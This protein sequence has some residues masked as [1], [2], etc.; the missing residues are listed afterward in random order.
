MDNRAIGV[1]DS[2][3]GGLTA[4]KELHRLL[5]NEDIIY[6]G[7]TGRVPYGSRSRE[8]IIKYAQ[9]DIDFL[10]TKDIKLVLAACGTVSSTLPKEI[11]GKLPV[12][13]ADIVQPA[14]QQACALT[15]G[16]RIGVVGTNATLRSNAFGKAIRSIRADVRVFGNP[17]P[18]LVHLVENGMVQPD[19]QITNLTVQ[20]YLEPL[21]REKIDTLILGCTHYPLLYDIFNRLLG[22]QVTLIDPGKCAAGYVQ[23]YLMQHDLLADRQREGVTEYN[24]TDETD[25]FG[26]TASIFLGQEVAGTVNRVELVE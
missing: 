20:M 5:P 15:S 11:S 23:R 3:L 19:N 24:V 13:Y 14:A 8:T 9:Q 1:F 21:M 2:G 12:P 26:K 7:D 18:L 22:Y 6:L 17:C 16:R 10:L 25:S 4:V